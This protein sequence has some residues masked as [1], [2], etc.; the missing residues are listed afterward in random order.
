MHNSPFLNSVGGYMKCKK[1]V[2]LLIVFC[3]ASCDASI[4][5]T[6]KQ[7]YSFDA[8]FDTVISYI[9]WV[10]DEDTQYRENGNKTFEMFSYY[11]QLFDRFNDYENINNI[12]KINDNAGQN[13]VEVSQEIIDMLL[14][15]K[16]FYDISYGKIDVTAGKMISLWH[17]AR[18]EGMKLNVDGNLGDIPLQEELEEA[19]KHRGWDKIDIND[20]DNTVFINDPYLSL[21]VGAIAKGYATQKVAEYLMSIKIKNA[22]ID[23]GG[24]LKALS[25]K[26]N[27]KE[28]VTGIRDPNNP[29]L[30]ADESLLAVQYY[31]DMAAVTSGDYERSYVAKDGKTYSHIIDPDTT[32]P[33][34]KYR[35]VTIIT[36]DAGAADCLS[37][38]LFCL[39]Y[40]DG[41]KVIER[42]KK[43]HQDAFL[44]VIWV[45]NKNILFETENTISTKQ[46]NIAYTAGL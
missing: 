8:G 14:E 9:E 10:K 30:N 24:N 43:D 35:S 25:E 33:A 4:K 23:A 15:A 44:E 36:K 11:N 27:G 16:Y 13:A 26:Y 32:Y 28:W 6:Q 1:I 38:A 31:G 37:T 45:A 3:L 46:Y 12:K 20:E 7:M 41:L 19:A 17:D 42:Y 40:E 2:V 29:S 5:Y 22:V 18:E 21:D 34:D 39:D